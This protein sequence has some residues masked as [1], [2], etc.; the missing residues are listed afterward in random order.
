M[1]C[2]I[3]QIDACIIHENM[4]TEVE[5][6]CH[7]HYFRLSRAYHGWIRRSN[8]FFT[9]DFQF[10]TL[11]TMLMNRLKIDLNFPPLLYHL[12]IYIF[13]QHH[14]FLERISLL[15]KRTFRF[16][17]RQQRAYIFLSLLTLSLIMRRKKAN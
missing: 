5:K 10:L 13:N 11:N 15:S 16:P 3:F 4:T 12:S 14:Q 8:D 2:N 6:I 17:S 9:V 7:K 1:R